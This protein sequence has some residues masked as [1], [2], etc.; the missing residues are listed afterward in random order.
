[1]TSRKSPKNSPPNRNHRSRAY[2][3][4][5]QRRNELARARGF[6]SRAEER[7]FGHH[8]RNLEE[9]DAF[10]AAA[11]EHRAAALRTLSFMRDDPKLSLAAAA[12]QNGTTPEAVRWFAGDALTKKGG[13][14]QVSAADRLFRPMFVY[15][16]GQMVG[17]S[18]R[19]SRKA[20]ELARYHGAVRHYLETGDARKL[21]TFSD[22]SVGGSPYETNLDTLDD[23][24]LRGQLDIDSIYQLVAV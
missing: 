23:M 20:S 22:K 13:R 15:S 21:R 5:Q 3:A 12:K 17:V 8:V 18:V 4:E 2:R 14:W 7:R 6:R 1:M 19:G 9:L 11:Q 10:P 16:E 24:A